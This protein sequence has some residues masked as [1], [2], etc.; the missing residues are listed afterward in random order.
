MPFRCIYCHE[1]GHLQNNC[2]CLC[3]GLPINSGFNFIPVPNLPHP[4]TCSQPVDPLEDSTDINYASSSPST[5]DD[6]SK[7]QLMYI[8]DMEV[9]A[10][11]SRAEPVEIL[12]SS[13]LDSSSEQVDVVGPPPF[14]LDHYPSLPQSSSGSSS[15]ST[16]PFSPTGCSVP[17]PLTSFSSPPKAL[18]F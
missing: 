4:E 17:L 7:G 6:L 8:E 15:S 5:F 14:T 18:A 1:T 2:H 13:A 16:P 10:L 9:I 12:V 3:T 11:H